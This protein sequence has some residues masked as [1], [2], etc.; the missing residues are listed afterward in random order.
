MRNVLVVED[1]VDLAFGL[2]LN[3]KYEGYG[4]TAVH[5]GNDAIDVVRRSQVDLVILDLLLPDVYGLE[6]LRILR[7]DG[8]L[9]PVIVLSAVTD[10]HARVAAFRCGADDYVSKPFSLLELLERV[11]IRLRSGCAQP[12]EAIGLRID[13]ECHAVD[14]NGTPL[15]L[16]PK[17]FDLLVTLVRANGAICSYGELLASVWNLPARCSTRT[18]VTHVGTL[19]RKLRDAG[20]GHAIRT[21]PRCGVAWTLGNCLC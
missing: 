17:E 18:A 15:Q 4:A 20:L 5:S 7:E 19:R 11:K 10:E 16:S 12:P 1:N 13:V 9:T 3:L 14:V 6:V 21:V 2:A 8:V